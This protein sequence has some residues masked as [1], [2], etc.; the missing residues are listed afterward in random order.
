[1]NRSNINNIKLQNITEKIK[2]L[3][4]YVC[5][6]FGETIELHVKLNINPKLT[7]QMFIHKFNLPYTTGKKIKILA[8]TADESKKEELLNAGAD[9]IADKNNIEIIKKGKIFFDYCVASPDSM[10]I[11]SPLSKIL[12]PKGLMPNVKLGTLNANLI[13][14]ITNLKQGQ[15]YMKNDKFG[16][17][18]LEIA[19]S[20]QPTTQIAENIISLIDF[21]HSKKPNSVKGNYIKNVYIATTH[22]SS[23][24]I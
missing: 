18:H 15:I 20:D 23:F 5:Y 19:K 24:E 22:G 14:T 8:F 3:K 4:S 9:Y 7:D 21:V 13:E 17:V 12:G 11:L 16:I 10:K 2:I 1:M 6:D